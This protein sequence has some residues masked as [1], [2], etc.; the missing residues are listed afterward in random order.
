MLLLPPLPPPLHTPHF[1]LHRP[2]RAHA[3]APAWCRYAYLLA[4]GGWLYTITDVEDLAQWMVRGRN[5][6][7]GSLAVWQRGVVG[8]W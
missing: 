2:R 3:P 4:P 6:G 8:W 1:R 7:R 5:G